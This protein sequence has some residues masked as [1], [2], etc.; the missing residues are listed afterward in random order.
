MTPVTSE[1]SLRGI[2]R[3][4]LAVSVIIISLAVLVGGLGVLTDNAFLLKVHPYIFFVGFGNL[5]ILLFNRYLT[6]AIYPELK[7]HP[8][9]QRLFIGLVLLGLVMVS[10]AVAFE[11]PLLKAAAGL[12]LMGVVVVP[13]YEILTTLSVSKIW[14]EVSVRYY[15]FDV[16]F[17]LNANLGLFTLGLKE[18]FPDNGIIPFFVTQSSYFLGSS[19]PLSISVMG[20]L[21]TYAWRKSSKKEL[22]KQLFS[23]WFYLFV[24]G[25]LYFLIVIL[26]GDYLGMMLISHILT[27]GVMAL[28]YTFGV[29]LCNYFRNNFAHPALAFLLGGLAF[30]FA[31]SAFGILN[32]YYAKGIL[33]GSY[34]P[35]RGD[36]MWIYHSHT[37]SALLGWITLSF[38]GMIYIVLPAIQKIGSLEM[39]HS[40]NPLEQLLDV[41][42]MSRAFVQL[43]LMLVSGTVIIVSFFTGSD[44]ALG[45]GGVAYAAA[46]LYLLRNLFHDPVFETGDNQ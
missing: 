23:L 5:A 4:F 36:K 45:F 37:H 34:P 10:V 41:H 30:L 6:A 3:T 40:G 27:F 39:L 22:A 26:L 12:M 13:L 17:L 31:T 8:A 32:I 1:P 16:V 42:T 35:I 38:T 15:I 29:F 2:T 21:Y 28:L 7:I 43:A 14:K 44:L 18:A 11:L 9:R 33:F 20:F 46:A 25:V 19:F 24:G